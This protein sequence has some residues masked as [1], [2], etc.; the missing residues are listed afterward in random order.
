MEPDNKQPETNKPETKPRRVGMAVLFAVAIGVKF[1]AWPLLQTGFYELKHR[2]GHGWDDSRADFQKYYEESYKT[3]AAA[4]PVKYAADLAT[5]QS[6]F[7]VAWL[8]KSDCR[9]YRI[10]FLTSAADHERQ[11]AACLSSAGESEFVQVNA[12]DCVKQTIPNKWSEF[13]SVYAER[14]FTALQADVN[15]S[16]SEADN[17]RLS[18][19]IAKKYVGKMT[20]IT[21]ETGS[22]CGPMNL[23]G[24]DLKDLLNP[25]PC[26]QLNMEQEMSHFADACLIESAT[27]A[28]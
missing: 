11:T 18:G 19:C 13:E 22:D 9:R 8:N 6:N 25:A 10:S 4:L 17:K 1:I 12:L 7:Y 2:S 20:S 14:F 15:T 27:A 3:S 21:A 23:A 5:C 16:R 24:T 28:H 26:H